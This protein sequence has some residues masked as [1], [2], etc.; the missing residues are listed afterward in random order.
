MLKNLPPDWYVM[1]GDT[2]MIL[3]NI[4]SVKYDCNDN[5]TEIVLF[6]DDGCTAYNKD[7]YTHELISK[8]S[9]LPQDSDLK[10]RA[11]GETDYVSYFDP[12]SDFINV[13][14]FR[15]AKYT[16]YSSPY[17]PYKQHY[18]RMMLFNDALDWRG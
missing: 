1:W 4:G 7:V 14:G 13:K 16:D 10:F 2:K 15:R 8:L 5:V 18:V 17:F 3:H 12:G 9:R 6:N 11:F